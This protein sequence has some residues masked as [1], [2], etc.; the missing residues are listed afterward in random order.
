MKRKVS[1]RDRLRLVRLVSAIAFILTGIIPGRIAIAFHQAPIPQTIL[2]LG[3]AS[4]RM[5]F[6]ARF[7]Q[8]HTN[9]DIW[10]SDYAWNLDVNRRIFQQFDVPN[11][12][13]HLDGRAT[14]TVTNFTTLVE[15]FVR[16]KLQHIYLITSD[17]H[18]KRAR[19]IASIVLGSHGIAVTPV[20]VPSRGD[21]SET[22][23]RVLRDCGRSVVWI[24]T[25][26]TGASLNPHLML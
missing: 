19:A 16:Q 26:R 12:R 7:W 21:K 20:G 14:D 23:V 22:L 8:S 15:D 1:K 2:V 6:A 11:Q 4:E 18:M 9:L 17:Y 10:V 3:S 24:F 5:E 25:G 13:L